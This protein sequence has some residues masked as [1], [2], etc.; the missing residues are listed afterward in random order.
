MSS[1]TMTMLGAITAML[2]FVS[3]SLPKDTN[4]MIQ[5][6]IGALTAGL[7]FYLGKTHSGTNNN[8]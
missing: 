3:M 2:S 5:I 7:S 6:A 1:S 8:T 4:Q